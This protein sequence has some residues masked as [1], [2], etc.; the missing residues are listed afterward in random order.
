VLLA[1]LFDT[2]LIF[3]G[4]TPAQLQQAPHGSLALKRKCR[5]NQLAS[6][7]TRVRLCPSSYY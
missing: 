2:I 6:L 3:V 4:S 5:F 7:L 1:V